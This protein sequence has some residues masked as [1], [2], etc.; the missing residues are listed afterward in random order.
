MPQTA[1]SGLSTLVWLL[2]LY[3]RAL[4]CVVCKSKRAQ[5]TAMIW[6]L[7]ALLADHN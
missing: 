5:I 3:S 7:V 1:G 4:M 2:D 6:E